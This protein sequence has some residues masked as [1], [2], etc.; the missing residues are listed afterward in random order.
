MLKEYL[1]NDQMKLC[2]VVK[3]GEAA[4]IAIPVNSLAPVDYKRIVEMETR[5]GELMKVMRDTVLDNGMNALVQY[6]SLFITIPKPKKVVKQETEL[7]EER[8]QESGSEKEA[9]SEQSSV[10]KAKRGRGRPK[11]TA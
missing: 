9:K 7:L 1:H 11:K 3:E 6:Q 4:D 5:G 10:K 8:T 2:F